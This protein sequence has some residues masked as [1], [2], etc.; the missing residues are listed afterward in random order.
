M[1]KNLYR[2]FRSTAMTRTIQLPMSRRLQVWPQV[3][4]S[5]AVDQSVNAVNHLVAMALLGRFGIATSPW[6]LLLQRLAD[7]V[8]EPT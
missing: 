8:E 5:I 3:V 6:L 4:V 7:D 1:T 2:A